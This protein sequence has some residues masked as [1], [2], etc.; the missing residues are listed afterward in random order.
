[1]NPTGIIIVD[2][3]SRRD[4]SNA[5]LESFADQFRRAGP[6]SIVEAAHMELAEP[7]IAAAFDRCVAQGARHIV[8]APYFLGPG[9][10]W[11]TDIP[12]LSRKAGEKHPGVT[13]TVAAP[14]GLHP[15]MIDVIRA[16]IREAIT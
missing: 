13:F 3:G 4:E 1:M 9:R 10:H 16:R 5:M 6:Y 2:H 11:D 8:V 7:S 15:L 12:N 14:I